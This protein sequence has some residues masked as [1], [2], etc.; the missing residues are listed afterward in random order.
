MLTPR[1]PFVPALA[2]LLLRAAHASAG[3]L[4][5]DAAGGPG[6][7][8]TGLQAAI[9]AATSGD[10]L[11]VRSG[12][13]DGITIDGKGLVIVA[14]TG[15][16]VDVGPDLF[17]NSVVKNLPAGQT[18]ALRGLS[19][20]SFW[21]IAG[22][23][24][25]VGFTLHL[26]DCAGA[27]WVE[28]CT[29]VS[30]QP[31]LRVEG[32]ADVTLVGCGLTGFGTTF[33]PAGSGCEIVSSTAS[34]VTCRLTG[35]EGQDA[36]NSTFPPLL[37]PA[38]PGGHGLS[39][40]A[41]LTSA[42]VTLVDCWLQGGEGGTGFS[43]ITFCEPPKA[44]G[45]GMRVGEFS[46]ELP[47]VRYADCHFHGGQAGGAPYCGM[48]ASG[49]QNIKLLSGTLMPV[50]G[51]PPVLTTTTPAREGGT[52]PLTIDGQAG[53]SALLLFSAMPGGFFLPGKH[54]DL[55]LGGTLLVIPLLPLPPS[56]QLPLSLTV[57]ELG[58][59]LQGIALYLQAATCAAGDC[60]LGTG[61]AL[62]LL[63]A[64]F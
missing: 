9:D 3:V 48:P 34:I 38:S 4:V 51:N 12:T 31:S 7:D 22:G 39:V 1:A 17:S 25:L 15:A 24:L 6:T 47:D 52:L 57:P 61:S 58:A 62:V 40:Q 56:G 54:G 41:G 29:V 55:L 64:S 20:D 18:V 42:S 23:D 36:A 10:V 49:G 35:G 50:P 5:V 45:D 14:D 33:N 27:V 37:K 63:D 11:L 26:H 19:F 59:G 28:D 2:L 32:C 43:D 16:T 44:G 53:D 21:P 60:T 30:G 46:G 13:Y 8:F